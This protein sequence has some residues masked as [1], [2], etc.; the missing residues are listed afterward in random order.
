VR[1]A[2]GATGR[3]LASQLL[4]ESAV[5]AALGI[6][7]GLVVALAGV[8]LLSSMAP[9]TAS[10]F[11]SVR[12]NLT[13]VSLSLIGV[14]ARALGACVAV[15]MIAGL[16]AG[17]M[18][19]LA[20]VRTPLADAIRQGAT[21]QTGF[22]GL[23]RVTAR[24][25]LVTAEIALAVV[26]LVGAGLMTRSLSRL[27]DAPLGY[28]PDNLLTARVALN[29]VRLNVEG[30]GALWN[31]VI[32]RAARIP[33]VAS[34]AVASCAPVGDHCEGTDVTLVGET[35]PTHVSFHIVSPN[36][37]NT[38]GVP[39]LRG[40][41]LSSD[42]RSDTP[43]VVL[44][45]A[46]AARVIWKG[47]DPLTTPLAWG[48]RPLTVVGI[49]GDVR[50]ED[51]EHP[52]QPAIFLSTTQSTRRS[53]VVVVRTAGD[54]AALGA[55]LQREIRALDRNH[56]ITAVKTMRE[57]LLDVSARSRFATR[58]L[59]VFA[60]IALLLAALGV[61]GIVSLAVTQ[62]R[63]ELAV[64]IALGASRASV[65]GLVARETVV[66]VAVGAIVG[67]IIAL[68]ASRGMSSLLYGVSV[69]D[70]ATYATCAVMLGATWLLATA[71]PAAR[72]MRVHP[73]AAL[74]E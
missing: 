46:T 3:R 73:A 70:S 61:Y 65:L 33:G 72:A 37:F 69:A 15:A 2:I 13:S 43:P 26:L 42:D 22:G 49:V 19:A 8:R 25:A 30:G 47:R 60:A 21:T 20:A 59:S 31:E 12:G 52:A 11:S 36:Y 74:R 41:D 27:F 10:T 14:D 5:L 4:T 50:Y 16:G 9:L 54:P 63:R 29:A 40:R 34:A 38:L 66:L 32:Q 24:G 51:V 17:L 35:T 39:L 28:R 23:R 62:R 48:A 56:T 58:V 45:N 53:S 68:L 7:A 67:A 64:R 6:V 57:R 71:V 44:I 18:P 1:L 55:A